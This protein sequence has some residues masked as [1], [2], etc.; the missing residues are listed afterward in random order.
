MTNRTKAFV[1]NEETIETLIKAW[2]EFDSEGSGLMDAKHFID[3]VLNLKPP[4]VL[5]SQ[6][7]KRKLRSMTLDLRA[8]YSN[9]HPM[10][11]ESMDTLSRLEG[12]DLGNF[13]TRQIYK[14]NKDKTIRLTVDQFF[15][16]CRL[17]NVPIYI[18]QNRKYN[19]LT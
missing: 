8:I 10:H 15:V 9:L 7:L 6:E 11:S 12:A 18:T 14:E 4:I 17:Y 5:S 3:F 1:F 16:Y 13:I 19:Y 2:M